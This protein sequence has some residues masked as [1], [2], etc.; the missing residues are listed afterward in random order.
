LENRMKSLDILLALERPTTNAIA[1]S[2]W[3]TPPEVIIEPQ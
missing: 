1:Y 3:S 2:E